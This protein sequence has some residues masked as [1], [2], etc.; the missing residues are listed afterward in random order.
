MRGP[1]ATL[2]AAAAAIGDPSWSAEAARLAGMAP[3][4]DGGEP[5]PSYRTLARAGIDVVEALAGQV[6]WDEAAA[7]AERLAGYFA[8]ARPRL[9]A[10]AGEGF[11]GLHAAA[12]ARDP[13]ELAD[14][15]G[16]LRE[17]FP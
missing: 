14:F 9:H 16:L 15:V 13:E 1:A 2:A 8:S 10:V 3:A 5:R 17:L 4:V 12:R 6:R 11:D 7:Q